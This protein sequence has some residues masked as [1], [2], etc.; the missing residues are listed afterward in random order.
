M[1]T[2]SDPALLADAAK[3]RV[4]FA[5]LSGEEAQALLDKFYATPP[6]LIKKA[7]ALIGR[8]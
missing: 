5:P 4:E 2:L 3:L 8:K 6:A 7:M 1:T